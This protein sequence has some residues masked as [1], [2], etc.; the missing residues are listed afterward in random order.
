MEI[1]KSTPKEA[2]DGLIK[3][4]SE[5]YNHKDPYSIGEIRKKLEEYF[6]Q[7]RED[8][9]ILIET[10]YVDKMYRDLYY[11]YF[12]TKLYHYDRNCIRISFFD[13]PIT[14]EK[15]Y[16]LEGTLKAREENDYLGFLVI[17]PTFPQIIGR[18]VLSPRALKPE[19][20]NFRICAACF[21]ATANGVKF[22]VE[23]FPHASKDG[24][25]QCCG[26][27]TIWAMMEYFGNKYPEYCVA[28]PS[29]IMASLE[30]ITHER[31]LPTAGLGVTSISYALKKQGLGTKVFS[32]KEHGDDDFEQFFSCYIESGLPVVAVIEGNEVNPSEEPDSYHAVICIGHEEEDLEKCA[33]KAE[34]EFAEMEGEIKI[35]DWDRCEK[36]FIF[37]DDNCPPYRKAHLNKPVE[38]YSKSAITHFVVPLYSKIYL[39]VKVAKEQILRY[40]KTRELYYLNPQWNQQIILRVFLTSSRSYKQYIMHNKEINLKIQEIICEL[41]VPKFIWVG[42][43]STP[44]WVRKKQINGFIILDA[45][46]SKET[47]DDALLFITNSTRI[48]YKSDEPTINQFREV[49]PDESDEPTINQFKKVDLNKKEGLSLQ[50]FSRYDNNLKSFNL[51][52]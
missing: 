51:K 8:I 1:S 5:K 35:Y 33:G 28:L 24:E 44:G 29:K 37:M 11:N 16:T 15:F 41:D 47:G 43:L 32:R 52:T 14:D 23:G 7:I 22:E 18:N 12:S 50:P 19:F 13:S 17:R 6:G 9:H 42:E 49:G 20:G 38:Y 4:Y 26:D 30:N 34:E 36:Q 40:I 2:V 45:T 10:D 3:L 48:T 46:G 21:P 39:D 31:L 25:M 27:I